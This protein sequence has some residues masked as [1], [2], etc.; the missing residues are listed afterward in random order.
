M[1]M[2]YLIVALILIFVSPANAG[3]VPKS[4]IPD[5]FEKD[6]GVIIWTHDLRSGYSK[7]AERNER[8]LHDV[9]SVIRVCSTNNENIIEVHLIPLYASIHESWDEYTLDD[10][11]AKYREKGCKGSSPL[12]LMEENI[13]PWP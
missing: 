5:S 10:L 7:I 8:R 2:R 13:I 4:S 12:D 11:D 6:A 1:N 3:V 9:N